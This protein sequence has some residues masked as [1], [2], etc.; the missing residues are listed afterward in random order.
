MET[1]GSMLT[2]PRLFSLAAVL[3]FFLMAAG[4][5]IFPKSEAATLRTAVTA[6][7]ERDQYLVEFNGS[8]LPSN[9]A[10][11]VPDLTAQILQVGARAIYRAIEAGEIHFAETSDGVILVCLNSLNRA[12]IQ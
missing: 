4:A 12:I 1:Y 9:A 5:T 6:P 3:T 10:H 8:Q 2:G 11:V 7:E